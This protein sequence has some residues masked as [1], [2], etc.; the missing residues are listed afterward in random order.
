[1]SVGWEGAA[2]VTRLKRSGFHVGTG[3]RSAGAS[4]D[5]VGFI[6]RD[7]GW[8][9]WCG[10]AAWMFGG[11]SCEVAGGSTGSWDITHASICT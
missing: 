10:G 2:R 4:G 8:W 11:W 7:G 9:W 5:V 3:S 6:A 1:M